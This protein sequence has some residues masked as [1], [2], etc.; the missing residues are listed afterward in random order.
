MNKY[1][2]KYNIP[3]LSEEE[4]DSLNRL[5]TADAIEA[6]IKKLLAHKRPEPD[7]FRETGNCTKLLRKS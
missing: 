5:K 4:T 2:E 6:V 3:K 7:G 1:P